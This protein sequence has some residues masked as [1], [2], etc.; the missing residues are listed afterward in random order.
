VPFVRVDIKSEEFGQ[1]HEP[2]S[3]WFVTTAFVVRHVALV[4]ADAVADLM[5]R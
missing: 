3:V 2:P 1:G 4:D 5:L